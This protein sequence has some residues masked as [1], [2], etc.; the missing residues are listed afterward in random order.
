MGSRAASPR[1]SV[2]TAVHAGSVSVV[3]ECHCI[4]SL[5]SFETSFIQSRGAL[6]STGNIRALKTNFAIFFF[7]KAIKQISH[8]RSICVS[9]R[10]KQSRSRHWK[11]NI[12]V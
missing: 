2:R 1:A 10:S 11:I 9:I 4:R 6:D 5:P 8:Q 12:Q 7:F 3:L